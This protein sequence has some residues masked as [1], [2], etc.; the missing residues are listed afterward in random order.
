MPRLSALLTIALFLSLVFATPIH[1]KKK[2]SFKIK[3]VPNPNY[4]PNGPAAY[5]RALFKFGFDDISFTPGGEVASRIKAATAAALNS[6]GDENGETSASP[7]QNNAQFLS[8]V[9]VGGQQL[10]MNFDSGSSDMYV[11]ASTCVT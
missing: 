7:S 1:Q 5:R 6:T 11:T 2:R 9:T 4:K 8:P 3:R 10:V